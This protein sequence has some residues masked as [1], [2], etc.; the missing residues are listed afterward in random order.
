[1]TIALST[2]VHTSFDDAVQRTREA[3]AQNGFGVL[4]EID[5]KA[6]LKDKLGAD[7]ENYMILGACNPPLAHQAVTVDPQIG[8]LLPCN[9]VVRA[10]PTDQNTVIV[11]AMNR[12][13]W[14]KS[15]A[16]LAWNR[17]PTRSPPNCRPPSIP[18]PH[19]RSV[20]RRRNH[21]D[22]GAR[23]GRRRAARARGSAQWRTLCRPHH[24]AHIQ[25][26]CTA[27]PLAHT[28]RQ[29]AE[30]GLEP[31]DRTGFLGRLGGS[32]CCVWARSHRGCSPSPSSSR[33]RH[34]TLVGMAW[35][36]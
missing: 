10:D 24:D 11:E 26:P 7:M 23:T 1:M 2:T 32:C 14:S 5:V 27:S 22:I 35:L 29:L 17:W 18:S 30:P 4:T 25:N 3:L 15:P 13:Y 6:T 28:L 36:T 12:G 21:H 34:N 19:R 16:R 20:P 9:V 31:E 8:L 33:R